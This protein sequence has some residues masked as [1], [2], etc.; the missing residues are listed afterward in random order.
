MKNKTKKYKHCH[1]KTKKGGKVIASG[2]Y[3]CVFSPSLV[4]Q[5]STKRLPNQISKIMTTNHAI[6]EY[7]YIK[8]IYAKLNSIPNYK[9]YFL[10]YNVSMCTPAKLSNKDL[11]HFKK[12]SA[13]KKKHITKDT[14]NNHL[15]KL[16]ILNLPNGGVPV[17]DFL[18]DDGSYEK[19]FKVHTLLVHLLKHGI[20]PM[21]KLHIYHSDIK[22]SNILIEPSAKEKARLIDWGLSVEYHGSQ[23]P[24]NWKNRPLQF[25]VPFSILLFSD[26]FYEKYTAYLKQGGTLSLQ[27]LNIFVLDYLIHWNKTRGAGHYKF[28]NEILY[29][30]YHKKFKHIHETKKA[31]ILETEIT[32]PYIVNYLSHVLIHYTKWKEDGTLNLRDYLNEVF[33]KIIDIW[34]LIMAYFPMLEIFS[35]HQDDNLEAFEHL[36]ELFY[37]YLF[38]PRHEPIDMDQL[39]KDLDKLGNYINKNHH[40]QYHYENSV[41]GGGINRSMFIRKK[42]V[43]HFQRPFLLSFNNK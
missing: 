40:L 10:I 43:K 4:C 12:C 21:N 24:Q 2:G 30:L 39:Y 15:D 38:K 35:N 14:I 8:H 25:N 26:S 29:L 6:D 13:L 5:G 32:I 16:R 11:T 42:S 31:L 27:E 18:Y 20:V 23:F 37:T 7:D 41:N 17:D 28:I 33:V 3:G 34:G 9:D 19:M 22:D 36:S 1:N